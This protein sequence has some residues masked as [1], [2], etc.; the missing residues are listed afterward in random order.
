MDKKPLISNTNYSINIRGEIK[1]KTLK[2]EMCGGSITASDN[3]ALITCDYCGSQVQ[4][5]Q[6]KPSEN[7]TNVHENKFKIIL[8]DAGKNK[9]QVIK[10]VRE[11]TNI[12]LKEAKD[13][14]DNAPSLIIAEAGRDVL[15]RNKMLLE[16]AGA[17][18]QLQKVGDF[19]QVNHTVANGTIVVAEEKKGGCYVATAVYGSYDCPEVW[20]LRRF[21]DNVLAQTWYGNLFIRLYYASSPAAVR[22]FG[23]SAW[24]CRPFKKVLDRITFSLNKKGI[25]NRPYEDK[26]AS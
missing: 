25:S 8:M 14:I 16:A 22:R 1:V 17:V 4:L 15:E 12:G 7:I 23:K 10:L 2:C 3:Q 18:V 21:R 11:I 24:F 5:E 26:R 9:I 13:A 19:A 6:S 20:T